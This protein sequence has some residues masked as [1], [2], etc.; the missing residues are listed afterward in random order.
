[1]W[2]RALLIIAVIAGIILGSQWAIT[3]IEKQGYDAGYAAAQSKCDAQ[4]NAALEKTRQIE[5]ERFLRSEKNRTDYLGEINAAKTAAASARSDLDGLRQY[6]AHLS[7][8]GRASEPSTDCAPERE[9]VARFA[10]LLSE[11]AGLV[12]EGAEL[13]G[14]GAAEIDALRR[15]GESLK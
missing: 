13:A 6:L 1:M 14:R 12:A 15:D 10:R 5:K 9:R 8:P 7:V 3:R 4:K 2:A 11:G